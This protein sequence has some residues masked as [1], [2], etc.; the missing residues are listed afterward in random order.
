[1]CTPDIVGA[2]LG[3]DEISVLSNRHLPHEG[4]ADGHLREMYMLVIQ[5][6]RLCGPT[7]KI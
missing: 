3:R 1:M 4:I 2:I 6:S 7:T 5:E